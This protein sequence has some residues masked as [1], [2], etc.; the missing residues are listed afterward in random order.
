MLGVRTYNKVNE[1][2]VSED[3]WKAARNKV[4]VL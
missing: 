2:I 4:K 3:G 1:S